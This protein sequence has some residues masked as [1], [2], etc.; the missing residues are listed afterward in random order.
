MATS[1][2]EIEPFHTLLM[3]ASRAVDSAV[4]RL[5]VRLSRTLATESPGT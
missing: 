5:Y 1:P 2:N 4:L 3:S